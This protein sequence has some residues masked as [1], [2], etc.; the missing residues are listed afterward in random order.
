ML[1][2]DVLSLLSLAA[3]LQRRSQQASE[4]NLEPDRRRLTQS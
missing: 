1:R 3:G 2:S 4:K